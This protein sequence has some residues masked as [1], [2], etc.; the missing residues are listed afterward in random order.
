MLDTENGR[1]TLYADSPGIMA[2]LPNGFDITQLDPPFTPAR[3]IDVIDAA[4]KAGITVLVIDS[5]SHE[6]EGTGGCCDI[7]ENNKLRG[8]PNW[9]KAKLAHKKFMNRLLSTN[10]HVIC[11]LRARDKVKM[12]DVVKDGKKSTEVVP[13]GI[14]PI[15]EKAFVFEQL[16][17]LQLEEKTHLAIPIKVPEPLGKFFAGDKLLTKADGERIREWNETG[18]VADPMD[19]IRKRARMEAED[20]TKAYAAFYASLTA[21][22]K[23]ALLDTTHAE[24]KRVAE[25][26]D[27]AVPTFGSRENH[28][29]WPE[30]FD[31]PVCI[32]NGDRYEYSEESSG[33]KKVTSSPAAEQAA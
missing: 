16:L 8:M 1:G 12:V 22:Q 3:Y 10:M 33:Y 30:S 26:A 9:S 19:Q 29:E 21:P 4:E 20:G 32:F 28:V 7:A 2:A 27:K 24:N 6:W 13:I 15:A 18:S 11:C 25:V 14:Q 31:G 5:A 17:S 23:K